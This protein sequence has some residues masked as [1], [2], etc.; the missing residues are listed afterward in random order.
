M[1]REFASPDC[2]GIAKTSPSIVAL[3]LELLPSIVVL[4]LEL[5]PSIVVLRLALLPSKRLAG[6]NSHGYESLRGAHGFEWMHRR[7]APKQSV[8]S[9]KNLLRSGLWSQGK[10]AK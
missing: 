6:T 1:L 7:V 2:V 3:R 8:E 10:R 9:G 5:S 4:R